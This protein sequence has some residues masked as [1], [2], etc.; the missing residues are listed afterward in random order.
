MVFGDP[1]GASIETDILALNNHT[2][3]DFIHTGYR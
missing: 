1:V 2:S 3:K